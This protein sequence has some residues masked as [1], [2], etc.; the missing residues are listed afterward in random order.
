MQIPT[1][2]QDVATKVHADGSTVIGVQ[3]DITGLG[4]NAGNNYAPVGVLLE[5]LSA[6]GYDSTSPNQEMEINKF[7]LGSKHS[8][9]AQGVIARIR[10]LDYG[11]TGGFSIPS[12]SLGA[13]KTLQ[14]LTQTITAAQRTIASVTTYAQDNLGTTTK[15]TMSAA[16]SMKQDKRLL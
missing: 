5:K 10:T 7:C 15:L 8:P 3:L 11:F 12:I 13:S 4:A 9:R 1:S 2:A 6:G 16:H 14:S